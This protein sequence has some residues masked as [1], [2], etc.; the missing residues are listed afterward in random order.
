MLL[1]QARNIKSLI[2]NLVQKQAQ[3][4]EIFNFLRKS[5][6]PILNLFT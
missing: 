6:K 2:E 4:I 5:V 3:L 1:G